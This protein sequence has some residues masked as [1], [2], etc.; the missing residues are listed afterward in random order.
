MKSTIS[1]LVALMISITI[2]ACKNEQQAT[3]PA[4]AE[5]AAVATE[6]QAATVEEQAATA[7]EQAAT[8]EEQAATEETAIG[9]KE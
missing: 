7:E 1:L 4:P 2:I 8:I 3:A 9:A 5:N 6:Q